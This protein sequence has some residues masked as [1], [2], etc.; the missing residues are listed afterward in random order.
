MD[1][2]TVSVVST[3]Y[4]YRH[5]VGDMIESVQEQDFTDWEL[6]IVDDG[7]TDSPYEVIG[8]YVKSDSRV[9]YISL[10]ENQGYSVAKN[11]GIIQARGAYLV[12]LDADDMLVPGSIRVR[13]EALNAYPKAWWCHGN[14]KVLRSGRESHESVNTRMKRRKQF[15]K[16][17]KD[18][19]TW[20]DSSLIH[21]QSVMLKRDLHTYVG[22]YDEHLPF[23]SD[24]EMWQRIIGLGYI[25]IHVNEWVCLY[26]VH[27]KQMHRSEKK[28]KLLAKYKAYR[29]AA[30]A[31]RISEGVNEFN[32]RMVI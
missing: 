14:A 2:P 24:T 26:R 29:K 8:S 9:R 31:R 32:T 17:G 11:E 1:S 10:G 3:L 12:M 30:T 18:L 25:P 6:V 22:L 15:I 5:Y 23:S 27:N 13:Y 20:Y 21:A 7:S 16:E 4:N 28:K 19:T